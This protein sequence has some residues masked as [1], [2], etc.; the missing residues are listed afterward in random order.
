MKGQIEEPPK[1]SAGGLS[2]EL[3][4]EFKRTYQAEFGKR[5]SDQ[6]ALAK[7]TNLLNLFRAIYRSIPKSKEAVYK[8][9]KS[10]YKDDTKSE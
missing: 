9:F 6:D 3:L 4:D 8:R 7:A 1:G 2:A 10:C 5:L